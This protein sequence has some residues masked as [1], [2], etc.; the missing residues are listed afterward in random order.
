[1][2]RLNGRADRPWILQVEA[3][4]QNVVEL[5]QILFF[6]RAA[7]GG[8][9]IPAFLLEVLCCGFSDAT[10]RAGNENCLLQVKPAIAHFAS[11]ELREL[12]HRET[13]AMRATVV[14]ATLT[15]S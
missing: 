15:L 5:G 2:A 13:W 10:T 6:L 11:H 9:D 4:D 1:Y 8:N 14:P 7:H 12:H 3:R